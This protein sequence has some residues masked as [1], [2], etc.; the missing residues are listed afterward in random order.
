[1]S[2]SVRC[3]I[4]IQK[5]FTAETYFLLKLRIYGFYSA[6]YGMVHL[7]KTELNITHLYKNPNIVLALWKDIADLN[8]K[9]LEF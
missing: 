1:M 8:Q 4:Y 5:E 2:N 6:P 3:N 9:Q 7:S